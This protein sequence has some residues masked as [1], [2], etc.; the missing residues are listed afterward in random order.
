MK[1]KPPIV[2]TTLGLA[3]LFCVIYNLR[4]QRAWDTKIKMIYS[5][6]EKNLAETVSVHHTL[7]RTRGAVNQLHQYVMPETKG[8]KN[9]AS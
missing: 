9:T 8:V 7:R 6:V 4:Q 2:M 3:T 5:T 1:E